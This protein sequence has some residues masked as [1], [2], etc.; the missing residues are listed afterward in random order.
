MVV[1]WDDI[2]RLH[3]ILKVAIAGLECD[4]VTL[5]NIAQRTKESI[6]VAREND[7]SQPA[8][9][10]RFRNV[11]NRSPQDSGRIAFDEHRFQ[12]ETRNFH[13][14]HNAA[15]NHATWLAVLAEFGEVF[16]SRSFNCLKGMRVGEN[17]AGIGKTKRTS[18]QKKVKRGTSNVFQLFPK[19]S[20]SR[21][22]EDS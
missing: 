3:S 22:R 19:V 12:A 10:G 6:T 11:A 21:N 15:L 5:L 14:A 4:H 13:F 1:W 7:I 8:R 2:R 9:P 20:S 18:C 17:V 16:K